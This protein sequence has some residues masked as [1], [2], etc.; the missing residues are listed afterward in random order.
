MARTSSNYGCAGCGS[1]RKLLDCY[2]GGKIRL[3]AKDLGVSSS[4]TLVLAGNGVTEGCEEH[5][6]VDTCSQCVCVCP[7]MCMYAICI[8][9]YMC[10]C[11]MCACS[12]C[13][14]AHVCTYMCACTCVLYVYARACVCVNVHACVIFTYVHTNVCA[15][16]CATCVCS[17]CMHVYVYAMLC[18]CVCYVCMC[19]SLCVCWCSLCLWGVGLVTRTVLLLLPSAGTESAAARWCQD[20]SWC[21]WDCRD[22]LSTTVDSVVSGTVHSLHLKGKNKRIGSK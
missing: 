15:H 7:C 13:A 8:L 9:V 16:I 2:T 18:V 22:T 1:E 3:G 21:V 10:I 11:A 14:S 5:L 6:A 17:M 12:L 19:M 4:A 20:P